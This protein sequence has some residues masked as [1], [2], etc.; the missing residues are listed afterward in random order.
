MTATLIIAFFLLVAASFVIIRS[1]RSKPTDET[2]FDYF[3]TDARSLFD[4]TDA[5]RALNAAA[6]QAAD[7]ARAAYEADLRGRAAR[8]EIEVL[9]DAALRADA[10]LYDEILDTLVA[11]VDASPEKL[12]ALASHIARSEGLRA[13]KRLAQALV[14]V[15]EKGGAPISAADLLRVAALSDDATAYADTLTAVY[16]GW[17]KG[18]GP[19]LRADEL[20]ELFEAEYQVLSPSARRGGSA[21]ILNDNLRHYRRELWASHRDTPESFPSAKSDDG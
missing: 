5:P 17:R 15:Y 7:E 8:G 11:N 2:G 6:H 12:A 18:R 13:N 1:K 9:D 21:Y 20:L 10:R 3:P 4:D 19:L 16:D 14:K